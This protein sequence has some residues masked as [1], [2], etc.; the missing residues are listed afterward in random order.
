MNIVNEINRYQILRLF[1][2]VHFTVEQ[3]LEVI[4]RI[5]ITINSD[6]KSD[7][8]GIALNHVEDFKV[9][10]SSYLQEVYIEYENNLQDILLEETDYNNVDYLD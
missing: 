8:L 3:L 5:L 2:K 6:L 9:R 1:M 10:E 7:N 4:R